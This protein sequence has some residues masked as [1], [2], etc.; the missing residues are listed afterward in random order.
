MAKRA[1]CVSTSFNYVSAAQSG[2]HRHPTEDREGCASAWSSTRLPKIAGSAPSPILPSSSSRN[3]TLVILNDTRVI[4]GA[5]H[6]AE[7]RDRR[8]GR[9]ISRAQG[10]AHARS[11][12]KR[13][14]F[15]ARWVKARRKRLSLGTQDAAWA[16][17]TFTCLAARKRTGSLEVRPR[18]ARGSVRRA[19]ISIASSRT[20]GTFR[21]PPYIKRRR[22]RRGSTKRATRPIFARVDRRHRS[23]HR[24]PPSRPE[25]LLGAA[26]GPKGCSIANA[27]TSA[28]WAR[29]LPAR[30]AWRTSIST[31]C[32]YRDA[33][34]CSRA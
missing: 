17:S 29:H 6:R 25:A 16:R 19:K 31:R 13:S 21:L 27:C 26:G 23:A 10:F 20:R 11:T 30:H 18:G 22:C 15:G 14:K 28:R 9:N 32:T 34:R 7:S 12:A 5:P 8:Q 4:S 2:S 33:T 24:G 1:R 3:V